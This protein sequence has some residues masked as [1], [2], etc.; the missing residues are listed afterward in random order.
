MGT[1]VFEFNASFSDTIEVE[2]DSYEEALAEANAEVEYQYHVV[3]G[4]LSVGWD[5]SDLTCIEEP[6]EDDED[7]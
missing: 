3:A 5:Y 1:Y 4:G 6:E 7:A 2:A